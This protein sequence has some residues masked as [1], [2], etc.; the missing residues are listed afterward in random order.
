MGLW[1][2][3]KTFAVKGNVV[4]LAIGVIVGASFSKVVSS[5]V[6][7]IAMPPLGLL[8]GGMDFSGFYI[9]LKPG[10]NGQ[11]PLI[12]NYGVF[13]NTLI[14]FFIVAW[15]VFFVIKMMNRMHLSS[16]LGTKE[17]PYCISPIPSKALRCK[18]CTSELPK[19]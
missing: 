6:A 10:S 5:L 4:D 17:C 3:F 16:L 2:E 11:P 13:I 9:V 12:L 1:T 8:I 14:D 15:I 7:D 19:K 18:F